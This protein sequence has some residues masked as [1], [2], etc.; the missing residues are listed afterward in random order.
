M[1]YVSKYISVTP[2]I[3]SKWHSKVWQIRDSNAGVE[4]AVTKQG[5]RLISLI[6]GG[7][8]LIPS[9]PEL[10]HNL[11]NLV[12]KER[13]LVSWDEVNLS[14]ETTWVAPQLSWGSGQVPYLMPNIG[15]YDVNEIEGGV[16][17]WS[18]LCPE[19]E[20]QIFRKIQMGLN[21]PGTILITAQVINNSAY[22]R[23][24]AAWSVLQLIS[25]ATVRVGP[26]KSEPE[27]FSNESQGQIP[28][29]VMQKTGQATYEFALDPSKG[30]FKVGFYFHGEQGSMEMLFPADSEGTQVQLVESFSNPRGLYP[31]KGR[32]E[33]YSDWRPYF[34]A[35]VLE[36]REL[37]QPGQRSSPLVINLAARQI[38]VSP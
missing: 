19:T 3:K 38:R 14:G 35:E 36:P 16:A 5:G 30:P 17:L 32:G 31:H 7:K 22:R 6:V 13:R 37:L 29:G 23:F 18:Q 21:G 4:A 9:R 12:K 1:S 15:P 24:A 26:L 11:H 10:F 34:E 27:V 28:N 25:P 8:E 20:L 2:H 33:L